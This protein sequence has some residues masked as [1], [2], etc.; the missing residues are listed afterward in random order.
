MPLTLLPYGRVIYLHP[1][2][3]S[4]LKQKP[5]PKDIFVTDE[6]VSKSV[7]A[8]IAAKIVKEANGEEVVQNITVEQTQLFYTKPIHRARKHDLL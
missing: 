5:R 3:I 4:M 2:V 7:K 1:Q 8:L 6:Y